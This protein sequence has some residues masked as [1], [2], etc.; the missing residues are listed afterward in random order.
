MLAEAAAELLN[1][2]DTKEVTPNCAYIGVIGPDITVAHDSAIMRTSPELDGTI[3][4]FH[5]P[6]KVLDFLRHLFHPQYHET[7][8][9]ASF[10]S[11]RFSFA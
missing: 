9:T 1:R 11:S 7:Q 2:K 6:V 5:K 3:P 4:V 8:R 10:R